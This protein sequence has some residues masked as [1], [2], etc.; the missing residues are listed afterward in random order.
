MV[1]QGLDKEEELFGGVF[2]RGFSQSVR[3]RPRAQIKRLSQKSEASGAAKARSVKSDVKGAVAI[4]VA[5]V[6]ISSQRDQL[7]SKKGPVGVKGPGGAMKSEDEQRG[8]PVLVGRVDL[9][10]GGG[11]KADFLKRLRVGLR[12][13]G[14][15]VQRAASG[16]AQAGVGG[17]RQRQRAIAPPQ[18]WQIRARRSPRPHI[19]PDRVRR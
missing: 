8:A 12:G 19:G 15:R 17:W 9:G 1:P 13:V 10:A 14:H 7:A 5:R 2:A 6:K 11:E 4:V 18:R 16:S 3:A